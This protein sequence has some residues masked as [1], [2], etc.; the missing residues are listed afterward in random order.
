MK[1]QATDWEETFAK[2]RYEK[3]PL[4]QICKDTQTSNTQEQAKDTQTSN[5][6]KQARVLNKFLTRSTAHRTGQG[7][8]TMHHEEPPAGHPGSSLCEDA[9]VQ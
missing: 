4:S 8:P 2:D 6:Q 5:T 1:G 3:G 7:A 9:E